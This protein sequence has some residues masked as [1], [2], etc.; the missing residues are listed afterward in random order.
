M[1]ILTFPAITPNFTEFGARPLSRVFQSPL[2]GYV[3]STEIPG[4]SWFASLTFNNLTDADQRVLAAFILS[5]RGSAGRFY[6]PDHALIT[7][8]GTLGGTPV[9]KG[10]SQTGRTLAIDG[11]TINITNWLRTG[12]YFHFDTPA[13]GRELKMLTA[14]ASSNGTG[15]VTLNFESAIRASP[16]DNAPIVTASPSCIMML[17]PDF[18][19]RWSNSPRNATTSFSDIVIECMEALS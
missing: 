13:G 6:L 16:A 18:V 5:L 3:Q 2:S 19:A 7:P 14:D 1:A 17:P 9:V 8:R 10:A 15:D 12:D 11:A 4:Q